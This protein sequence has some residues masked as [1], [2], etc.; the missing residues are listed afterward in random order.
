M[1]SLCVRSSPLTTPNIH[2]I[3]R[4]IHTTA[5]NIHTTAPYIHT[6]APN[7][8]TDTTIRSLTGRHPEQ[9]LITSE[10]CELAPPRRGPAP[11]S[12]AD[13]SAASIRGL[14]SRSWSDVYIAGTHSCDVWEVDRSP[15]PI[16]Y[17]HA[18]DVNA[19]CF[20]PQTPSWFVTASDTQ[21]VFIWDAHKRC[22]LAK[23]NV[24]RAAKSVDFSPDGSLLAVGGGDGSFVVLKFTKEL[25]ILT[26]SDGSQVNPTYKTNID[27]IIK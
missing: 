12:S 10:I 13:S 3:A 2:T 16:I 14:D 25:E 8:H 5:R 7:I 24:R 27:K 15:E 21:R 23:R 20:H 22:L 6:T 19:V 26:R 9:G 1:A 4:N 11:P 18:A 17:G